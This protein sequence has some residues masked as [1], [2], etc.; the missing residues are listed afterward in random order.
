MSPYRVEYTPRADRDL[1]RLP[2]E[3]ARQ[4]IRKIHEIRNDPYLFI[5]KIKASS[6]RHPIYSVRIRRGVRAFVSI[7]DEV[8][9]IHVLEVE[10]RKTAYRDF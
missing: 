4:V 7:H 10:S 6:P 3:T 2:P 9:I 8:L 1:G 5:K